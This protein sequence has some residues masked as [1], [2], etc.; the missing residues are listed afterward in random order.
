MKLISIFT[1]F[2]LQRIDEL[3]LFLSLELYDNDQEL[4]S[5]KDELKVLIQNKLH[6]Y[7]LCDTS[8]DDGK[9]S[10]GSKVA[11]KISRVEKQTS[12]K[13]LNR[14]PGV[15]EKWNE[16]L[17]EH[18]AQVAEMST[19]EEEMSEE[20]QEE[21]NEQ[22]EEQEEQEN[23]SQQQNKV[24]GEENDN[25]ND[26]YDKSG[27][28]ANSRDGSSEEEEEDVHNSDLDSLLNSS[29]SEAEGEIIVDNRG[30]DTSISSRNSGGSKRS[31]HPFS[32]PDT[33]FTAT[34][35]TILSPILNKTNQDVPITR[36]FIYAK[37]CSSKDVPSD[38]PK[39]KT[40]SRSVTRSSQ[41]TI[42]LSKTTQ[43]LVTNATKLK[44]RVLA[45]TTEEENEY[46]WDKDKR[47]KTKRTKRT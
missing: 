4:R 18:E 6:M 46:S 9:Q 32:Y 5:I 25:D 12:P 21:Q 2:I 41:L 10:T 28:D 19:E 27:P 34:E 14:L 47:K 11:V 43:P 13:I 24:I 45:V 39:S 35:E 42:P 37:S 7:D 38:D 36:Q 1:V 17:S 40:S 31:N 29:D 15:T 30:L 3:K 33:Q 20:E 22:E 26:T 16:E 44:K 23:N 8:S